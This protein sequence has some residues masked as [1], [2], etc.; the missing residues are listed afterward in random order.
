MNGPTPIMF[1]MFSEMALLSPTLRSREGT[2]WAESV[3]ESFKAIGAS[4]CAGFEIKTIPQGIR[5]RTA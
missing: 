4:N 5:R 3:N 1:I 2:D